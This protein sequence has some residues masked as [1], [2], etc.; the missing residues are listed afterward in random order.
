[1][2]NDM[3]NSQTDS[4]ANPS[5]CDHKWDDDVWTTEENEKV[6]VCKRC[7]HEEN[8]KLPPRTFIAQND[9]NKP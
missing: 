1:M 3:K 6:R 2:T 5:S 7:G 9:P 4:E 8:I